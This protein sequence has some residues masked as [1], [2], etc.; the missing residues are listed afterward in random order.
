MLKLWL[1]TEHMI[2]E[3][4]RLIISQ[5][6]FLCMKEKLHREHQKVLKKYI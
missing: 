6:I 3:I 1:K 5:L 4:K 2:K